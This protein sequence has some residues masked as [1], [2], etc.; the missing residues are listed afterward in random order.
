VHGN[1]NGVNFTSGTF[2]VPVV[3]N[4]VPAKWQFILQEQTGTYVIQKVPEIISAQEEPVNLEVE[5]EYLTLTTTA[6]DIQWFVIY[7]PQRRVFFIVRADNFSHW[8]LTDTK[9]GTPVKVKGGIGHPNHGE[10]RGLLSS[11][12]EENKSTAF[13]PRHPA[14]SFI[15]EDAFWVLQEITL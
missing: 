8:S 3:Q 9:A 14:P 2:P 1:I 10:L 15:D 4:V 12:F 11:L 5:N 7:E 13:T 6:L